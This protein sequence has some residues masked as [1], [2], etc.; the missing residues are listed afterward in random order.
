MI[1]KFFGGIILLS[2]CGCAGTIPSKIS[3]HS[4]RTYFAETVDGWRIALHR[5]EPRTLEDENPNVVLLVSS[6]HTNASFWTLDGSVNL[7][8]YL[9]KRGYDVWAISF[10]GTGRSTRPGYMSWSTLEEIAQMSEPQ[11]SAKNIYKWTLD[12]YIL[13]DLHAALLFIRIK[14]NQD[15]IT[16]IGHSFGG[17]ILLAYLGLDEGKKVDRAV[18]TA[19][20][21]KYLKPVPDVFA[22]SNLP[23]EN[24]SHFSRPVSEIL[25][26]NADNIDPHILDLS[27]VLALESLPPAIMTQFLKIAEIGELKSVKGR[28]NYFKALKRVQIPVLLLS[29]KKDNLAPPEGIREIYRK[30]GSSEKEYKEL[31]R[32]NMFGA[33]Y[34]HDDI[35]LGKLSKKEVYPFIYEWLKKSNEENE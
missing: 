23:E 33:D 15:R 20:P 9:A 10:R 19:P 11:E 24:G 4:P 29:G 25:F 8:R 32:A 21:F 30:L 27:A 35:I 28:R 14:T 13:K 34:G 26:Y 2:L 5:F 12:D 22:V 17:S 6:P 3:V 1:F 31:G 16:C 7:A 18:V